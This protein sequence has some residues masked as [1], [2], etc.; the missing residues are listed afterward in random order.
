[1]TLLVIFNHQPYDGTDVAWNA[2][3]LIKQA[4]SAG[5]ATRIFLMNEAIDLARQQDP[6]AD[7][8]DLHA[9]LMEAVTAGAEAKLCKTCIG[10]C[11]INPAPFAPEVQ[12][13]TMPELVDWV[14]SSDRVLTF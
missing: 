4:R 5:M 14:A 6:P 13:G 9:M 1:M 11:S 8:E 3:R 2:L 10:R 12:I 7:G